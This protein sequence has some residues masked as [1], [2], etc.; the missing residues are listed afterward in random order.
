MELVNLATTLDPRELTEI[1][2]RCYKEFSED[3][4][5]RAEWEENHALFKEIYYQKHYPDTPPW[6]GASRES[7][8]ILTEACNMFQARAYKAFFPTRDFVAAL[9]ADKASAG[10]TKEAERIA[11]YLNYQLTINDRYYRMDKK[12]M[13]LAVALDG[14]DFSKVYYDPLKKKICTDRVRAEDLVVPYTIGS[15]HIDTLERKTQIVHMSV[16]KTKMLVQTGFF[17]APAEPYFEQSTSQRTE[18]EDDAQGIRPNSARY[19]SNYA[20]ILEHHRLLDLDGDG[21]EE[22]YIVWQDRSSKKIMRIQVRYEVD[23]NGEATKN[24]EPMEYFVHYGFLPNPDGFYCNGL[25]MLVAPL[26]IGINKITRQIIDAGT[27]AN[28]GNMSGF[29]NE[30]LGVKGDG[31]ELVLGQF[32]K[33]PKGVDDIKKAIYQFQFPGPNSAYMQTLQMLQDVA[34][35]LAST[36]DAVTGDVQ[37]VIQPLSLMT[38]LESSLQMP[39]SVME[40]MALSMEDELNK[41]YKLYQK[42]GPMED[43]YFDGEEVQDVSYSDFEG[44]MR[45]YPIF[46]PQQVTR[47]QKMAKSQQ[48]YTFASQNPIMMQDPRTMKEVT[49]RVLQSFD[50]EDIQQLIPE[51]PEVQFLHN[52]DIENTYYLLPPN[53]RPPFD[54]DPK[55]NHAEHIGKIDALLAE[56]K[57]LSPDE[58]EMAGMMPTVAGLVMQSTDMM[59]Q[60]IVPALMEHRRKHFAYL[61]DE[62]M[63]GNNGGNGQGRDNQLAGQPGNSVDAEGIIQLLQS[64]GG[65]DVMLPGGAAPSAGAMGRN[66]FSEEVSINPGILGLSDTDVNPRT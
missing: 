45:V 14:S 61:H 21:I 28:V 38:M 56:L 53:E 33:I 43:F 64:T 5:S 44:N 19:D 34:N 49:K 2:E 24:K 59:L 26:N 13:F 41:I 22:P 31:V 39:T 55:D 51:E 1:A 48:L 50:T 11:A 30:A 62:A 63:V 40:Q 65:G 4:A 10:M 7:I 47:Q 60:D 25:G 37:K 16:N 66:P 20:C 17:I 35:R 58:Q 6:S 57:E 9:P 52:Q 15:V 3:L 36:T 12:E 29:M 8:P 27:L 18:V 46:D 23:Q 32:T 54:V 42:Y